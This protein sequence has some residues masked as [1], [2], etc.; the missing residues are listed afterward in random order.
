[1][2]L[3]KGRKDV[4][5]QNYS[6]FLDDDDDEQLSGTAGSRGVFFPIFSKWGYFLFLVGSGRNRQQ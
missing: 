1:M 6:V 3:E 4:F 5:T 2:V